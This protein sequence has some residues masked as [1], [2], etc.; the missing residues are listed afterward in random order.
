MPINLHFGDYKASCVTIVSRLST[1]KAVHLLVIP[2]RSPSACV[3]ASAMEQDLFLT[4]KIRYFFTFV[5][6]NSES[7]LHR[8]P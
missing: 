4:S 5:V 6:T 2:V 3:T 7:Y 1:T 8:V